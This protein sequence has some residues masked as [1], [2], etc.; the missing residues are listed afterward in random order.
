MGVFSRFLNFADG[1]KSH[2]AS[3]IFR[4]FIVVWLNE[5]M[6]TLWKEWGFKGDGEEFIDV[7]RVA[8]ID[9]LSG[10]ILKD[11]AAIQ[12]RKTVDLFHFY[13]VFRNRVAES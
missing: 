1:T 11:G 2:K 4:Y 13:L 6:M 5:N 3:H 8:E 12:A 9:K 10:K 7:T